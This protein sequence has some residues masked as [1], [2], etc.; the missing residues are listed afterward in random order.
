MSMSCAFAATIQR[1][2]LLIDLDTGKIT[3]VNTNN[4]YQS[5]IADSNNTDTTTTS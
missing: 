1:G 3:I 2:N 5:L 4:Q